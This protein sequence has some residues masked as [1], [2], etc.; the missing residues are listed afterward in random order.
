LLPILKL[1]TMK[2]RNRPVNVMLVGPASSGKTHMSQQ[3]AEILGR[4]YHFQGQVTHISELVGFPNIHGEVKHTPFRIQY[5]RPSVTLFD[6]FDSW[7]DDAKVGGNAALENSICSF[8]DKVEYRHP[9]SIVLSSGNVGSRGATA[10][11]SGRTTTDFAAFDR[12]VYWHLDI[13]ENL[14]RAL[15]GGTNRCK[16]R[17][18]PQDVERTVEQCDEWVDYVQAVRA[19]VKKAGMQLEISSRSSWR[20]NA[21]LSAGFSRAD[22]EM[23][24]LF[25]DLERDQVSKIKALVKA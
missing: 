25:K 21:L 13:D 1:C 24:V 16:P 23:M 17:K 7:A 11:Y 19:A 2:I 5:L 22:V 4:P 14:E 15:A 20:G 6:E 10:I 18:A 12:F 9:D 8:P 3:I